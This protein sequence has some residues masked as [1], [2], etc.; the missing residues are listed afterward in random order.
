MGQQHV[1]RRRAVLAAAAAAAALP[2]ALRGAPRAG[3]RDTG[4]VHAGLTA[5]WRQVLLGGDPPAGGPEYTA[6]VAAQDRTARAHLASLRTGPGRTTPFDDLPL[7]TASANVTAVAG[8]LRTIALAHATP[9]SALHGDPEAARAAAAGLAL[10]HDAAYRAGQEAYGNWWDWEIGTPKAVG[11]LCVLLGDAVG[12]ATR[13]GLLAATD[14]FVPDPRRMLRGT[15]DSTGANRVDLCRVVALRGALGRDEGKLALASAALAGVL[16]PV[17]VGDGFH[18]DGSF[19]MHTC[20]AYPGTYGEVLVRGVAELMKLLTGTPWDVAE[21]ERQRVVDAVRRT[22]LPLVHGGL[23]LDCVRGRAIS[24]TGARDADDGFLLAVDLVNLAGA[25]PP[26]RAATAGE[27]R[28]VAREWLRRNTWRPLSARQPAQI[29]AVAPVLADGSLPAP[30]PLLGHFAFPD[31]ERFVHRR[32]A[33]SASLSLNSDRV[34][35]YEYMNGENAKGWH[36]GD[37]MLLLHLDADPF[38]HTDGHWPTVDAKR[39]PGTTV[40]TAPL[41][42]GAGG[43]NDHEPLTGTRLSGG[44]RLDGYGLASVDLRGHASP[45]TAR[46][47]W[48]FLDDAVLHAGSAISATGGR[49]IETTVENRRADAPAA[50]HPGWAHLPGTGGHVFLAGPAPHTVHETRTGTWRDLNASGP[51]TPVTRRWTTLWLDHGTD[52]RDASYAWLQ[53]PTASAEATAARSAAPG[54]RV[55]ALT[56]DLHAFRTTGTAGPRLTAVTF[57]AP[58]SHA[59]ITVDAPCSVLLLEHPGRSLRV[60]VADPSRTAAT[61]TLTLHGHRHPLSPETADDGL[62]VLT[63][64]PLRLLAEPGARHGATLTATLRPGP[65]PRPRRAH[66]L[67]PTADATVRGDG[68]RDDTGPHLTVGPTSRA[69]LSFD[70]APLRRTRVHRAVLWLYGAVPND[71]ATREDDLLFTA[72][73]AH[74]PHR[75][76]PSPPGTAT[77]YPDWTALDVTEAARRLPHPFT[78]TLAQPTPGPEVRL[79]SREN[80]THPPLLEVITDRHPRSP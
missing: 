57:F 10:L 41:P 55:T 24:R 53:L 11:D 62:T 39:L 78:V 33:W 35:R 30:P 14:H 17:P 28:S 75:A 79:H 22:F 4:D 40:D 21:N 69:T 73:R 74:S 46:K 23:T 68:T 36:T 16:D 25:L 47:S 2:A 52:P 51:T 63:T 13:D 18:P 65:P 72:L 1:V 70:L 58:G 8:R 43:D 34:A 42:P 61:V 37:G 76:P 32:P 38:Q 60:A 5:R 80:P 64:S 6:A 29:A 12:P 66:L 71:P 67:R 45:L 31:M 19:L 15:L 9:A 59:G 48:L 56:P 77:V 7:G 26:E 3:A 27:L 54:V 49:R 50:V 20:V 44:V